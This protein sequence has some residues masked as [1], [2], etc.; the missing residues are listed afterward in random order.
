MKA[1]WYEQ[2]GPAAEVLTV[3]ELEDPL[4]GIGQGL[5]QAGE[6]ITKGLGNL[7]GG[8]NDD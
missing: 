1:A 7:L 5:G 2:F 8:D 4:K 3:G 6:D